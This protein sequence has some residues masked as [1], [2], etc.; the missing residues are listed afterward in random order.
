[1]PEPNVRYLQM[2]YAVVRAG[3]AAAV[4]D[5]VERVLGRKPVAFAELWK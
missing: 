4:T 1:M 5:D 3:Y 2:L